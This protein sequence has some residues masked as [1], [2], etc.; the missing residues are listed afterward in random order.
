MSFAKG[1]LA[2]GNSA[3]KWLAFYN[4][5][6]AFIVSIILLIPGVYLIRRVPE[7]SKKTTGT[8]TRSICSKYKDDKNKE[9][10]EC[11][12][13]YEYKVDGKL[14]TGENKNKG[15][16]K[17]I[18]GDTISVSYN[19][20][21]PEYHGVNVVNGFWIGVGL[22]S[23]SA[24][25]TLIWGSLWMFTKSTKGAGSAYLGTQVLGVN[26]LGSSTYS[27]PRMQVNR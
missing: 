16:K 19:P 9:G 17:F 2:V 14:F 10:W 18:I 15:S 20:N 3:G 4:F 25:I 7:F 12:Y 21:D 11:D 24:I 1:V 23:I 26:P 27:Q 8:V 6:K 22:V 5:I 13:D